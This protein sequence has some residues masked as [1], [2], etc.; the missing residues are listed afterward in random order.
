MRSKERT[1]VI[2]IV[3][4]AKDKERLEH[5]AKKDKVS[6]EGMLRRFMDKRAWI[7][8]ENLM[9]C[10]VCGNGIELKERYY[11]KEGSIAH[12]EKEG[13]KVVE[14]KEDAWAQL[15]ICGKCY[16]DGRIT[17]NNSETDVNDYERK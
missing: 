16:G 12:L 14:V 5:I 3:V 2:S 17:E 15:L 10:D 1:E 7:E 8:G 9:Y 11:V 4:S 13:K 6:I